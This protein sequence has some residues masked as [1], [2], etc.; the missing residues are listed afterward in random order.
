MKQGQYNRDKILS[1]YYSAV[2]V[3]LSN[4]MES[5]HCPECPL[6]CLYWSSEILKESNFVCDNY[7]MGARLVY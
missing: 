5:H 4:E 2:R 1:I 6:T 7:E 3:L